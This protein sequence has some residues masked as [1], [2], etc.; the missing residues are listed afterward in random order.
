MIRGVE[1]SDRGNYTCSIHSVR[2]S[3]YVHTSTTYVLHVQGMSAFICASF[4]FLL[5]FFLFL[6]AL[7]ALF[8]DTFI[9]IP[10][11]PTAPSVHIADATSSTL[12]VSWAAGDTGGAPVRAW[13]VWWRAA[14]GGGVWHTRELGRAHSRHVITDLQCGAEYQVRRRAL[15]GR[16]LAM[17][18]KKGSGNRD[19][20]ILSAMGKGGC[21]KR[22]FSFHC[23]GVSWFKRG[24][25]CFW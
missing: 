11:P 9:V 16:E 20:S 5:S 1:R 2:K 17:Q 12:T 6:T 8:A 3:P 4:F 19:L 15:Q 7:R 18:V 21:C 22:L 10:V 24:G 25:V 13:A 23:G 14:V